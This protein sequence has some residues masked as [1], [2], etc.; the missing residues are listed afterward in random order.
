MSQSEADNPVDQ[1]AEE[2]VAA[3]EIDQSEP[4][5]ETDQSEPE[6]TDQTESEETDQSELEEEN[7][8]SE[9]GKTSD[10]EEFETQTVKTKLTVG[11]K[12]H[13]MCDLA[14]VDTNVYRHGLKNAEIFKLYVSSLVESFN[15]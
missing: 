7:D 3:E 11:E 1:S 15:F 12:A 9:E 13:N 6:E 14:L 5:E 10:N 8:Q 2:P 4:A